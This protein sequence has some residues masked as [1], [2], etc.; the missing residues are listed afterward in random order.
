M[1]GKKILPYIIEKNL[2]VDIDD[3]VSFYKAEEIIQYT[4]CI[5]FDE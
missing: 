4:D 1:S 3:F 5:K 2:A